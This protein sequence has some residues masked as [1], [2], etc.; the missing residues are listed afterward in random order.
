MVPAANEI[1]PDLV[2]VKIGS[3]EALAVSKSPTPSLFTT[4]VAKDV[5][6][7]ILATPKVP[8]PKL[9]AVILNLAET[10]ACDP[11]IKSSVELL[12]TIDPFCSLNGLLIPGH[13]PE[14]VTIPRVEDTQL[15]E[16]VTPIVAPE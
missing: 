7:E 8:A 2:M 13:A 4:S 3:P 12:A 10:D 16:A 5:C 9:F 11:R 14:P 6:P 15:K 1:P